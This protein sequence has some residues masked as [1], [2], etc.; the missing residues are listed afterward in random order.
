MVSGGGLR[1]HWSEVYVEDDP[2]NGEGEREKG[3]GA[4]GRH[5]LLVDHATAARHGAG[6]LGGMAPVIA[7]ATVE[8]REG[9]KKR[10]KIPGKFK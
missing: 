1:R 3:E 5:G 2:G 10:E 7:V 8:E 4:G 9:K 6:Q